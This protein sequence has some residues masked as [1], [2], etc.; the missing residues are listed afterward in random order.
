MRQKK[1]F[2]EVISLFLV[3]SAGQHGT[4]GFSWWECERFLGELDATSWRTTRV[5]FFSPFEPGLF[6]SFLYNPSRPRHR[7][8]R[9]ES[10][11]IVALR[12]GDSDYL[13][14]RRPLTFSRAGANRGREEGGEKRA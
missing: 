9:E 10:R 2:V 14:E 4:K 6:S 11:R 13:E 3:L 5:S 1:K 8:I 12:P 7:S